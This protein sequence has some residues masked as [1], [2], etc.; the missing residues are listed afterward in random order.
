VLRAS[1]AD[2]LAA[3]AGASQAS[4]Q[5]AID[6]TG[7][8]VYFSTS[9]SNLV[10]DD[11]NGHSD[12]FRRDTRTG[13]VLRL[14]VDN[15]GMPIAGPSVEPAVTADGSLVAFVAPDAAVASL[16]DE[17]PKAAGLRRKASTFGVYLRNAVT[18]TTRR[19]GTARL[20]GTG[21]KP[22][23]TAMGD[24]LVYTS[25]ATPDGRRQA[26]RVPLQRQGNERLPGNPECLTCFT[27][28]AKGL[29]TGQKTDGDSSRPMLSAGGRWLVYESSS[30][31]LGGGA[32]SA[33]TTASSRI[34]LR[35][36]QTGSQRVVS[37][38]TAPVN[39]GAPGTG[40]RKPQIDWGGTVVVFESDQPLDGRENEGRS[41]I[42]MVDLQ[43]GALS[44]VSRDLANGH[45]AN[46]R[47]W[48][49]VLSGDGKV[50]GF[51]SAARNLEPGFADNN[52][53]ADVHALD[54]RTGIVSR[55]AKSRRGD[56]AN[57]PSEG[58]ALDYNGTLMVFESA[59]ANLVL[60]ETGSLSD[61]N[62]VSDVFQRRNPA[63]G[64]LVFSVGFE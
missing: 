22:Q 57:A 37:N 41:Q 43:S 13:T 28:S 6:Q 4:G 54:R 56:Q 11:V 60:S 34:V 15:R 49:P 8:F 3:S 20:G 2:V 35:N 16:A 5:G 29:P 64:D 46:D 24:W 18:G 44:R 19:A 62:G 26:Y 32:S 59:A 36:M 21:T 38:P 42:F 61:F 58:G 47:S 17:G 12:V 7:R 33:C 63:V 1:D 9:A 10:A 53:V 31:N 48:D 50:V 27:L 14:S 55:V 25:D 52:E 30:T 39:C 45:D 40:S 51:V 23:I